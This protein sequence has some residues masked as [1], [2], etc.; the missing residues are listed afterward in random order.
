MYGVKPQMEFALLPCKH[1]ER[2]SEA[3][4]AWHGHLMENCTGILV[5][6]TYN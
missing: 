4:L 5:S 3:M 2:G 1:S 6:R